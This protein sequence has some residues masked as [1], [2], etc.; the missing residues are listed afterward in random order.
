MILLRR[1]F[2][3][4]FISFFLSGSNLA[5]QQ[6]GPSLRPIT[7]SDLFAIRDVHEPRISPDGKWVAYTSN[8]ANRF[9]VYVLPYPGPGGKRQVSTGGGWYPRWR[10][11][12]REL[13]Y[14]STDG[15]VMAA[16]VSVRNGS[17]EVGQ[18]RRLFG[19]IIT[20]RGY[21]YDVSI[22]G[23][24]FIAALEREADSEGGAPQTPPLTLV[25]NWPA[26]I[27]K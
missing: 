8:E 11:D 7:I 1:L 26:L 9:E 17:L 5:A 19:G 14:I 3:L 10:R 12:G 15:Q 4:A 22:D 18:V 24:R 23:Q 6:S 27:K 25:E 21:L 13:F 2:G 16:E 20:G